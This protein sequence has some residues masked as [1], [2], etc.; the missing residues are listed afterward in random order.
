MEDC[1]SLEGGG[2]VVDNIQG[3]EVNI[4]MDVIRQKK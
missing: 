4:H 1:E 2:F 3:Q